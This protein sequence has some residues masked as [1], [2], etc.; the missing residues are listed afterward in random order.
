MYSYFMPL[1]SHY[2]SQAKHGVGGIQAVQCLLRTEVA[3][4]LEH[5]QSSKLIRVNPVVIEPPLPILIP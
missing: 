5:S 3:A 2:L 4:S 1:C